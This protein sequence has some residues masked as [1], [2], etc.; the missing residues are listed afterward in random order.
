[1]SHDAAKNAAQ[2]SQQ[3]GKSVDTR[4][5]SYTDRQTYQNNGG[6]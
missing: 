5:W 1:M 3:T 4:Q 2:W 6:K